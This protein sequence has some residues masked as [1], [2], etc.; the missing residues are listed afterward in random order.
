ME[1]E[2]KNI[3]KRI[4]KDKGALAVAIMLSCV[5]IAAIP[6]IYLLIVKLRHKEKKEEEKKNEDK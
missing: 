2:D 3:L 1:E 5:S 4:P 6:F